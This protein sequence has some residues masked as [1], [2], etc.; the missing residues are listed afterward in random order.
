MLLR[1]FY[2]L[3]VLQMLLNLH[4]KTWMEGLK[5]ANFDNHS[6]ENEKLVASMLE[7]AKSYHKV[8]Y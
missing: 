5:L 2:I 3:H 6:K 1:L 8:I 7:L 4:K